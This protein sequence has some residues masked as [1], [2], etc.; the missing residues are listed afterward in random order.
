MNTHTAVNQ[1]NITEENTDEHQNT[2]TATINNKSYSA[3]LNQNTPL[4]FPSKEQAIIFTSIDGA[5][6]QDYLLQLGPVVQPKNIIFS[7]RISNNRICVYLADK[8]TVDNFLKDHGSITVR[9]ETIQARRLITPSE[10]LVLS[11]VSPTIPHDIL[12]TELQK[13]GLKLMSPITF[14]RIGATNPEYSHILSFRRQVYIT[15]PDHIE[16]PDSIEI[17]HDEVFYRIFLSRDSQ[18]CFKCKRSGHIASQCT[19]QSN[20]PPA[21]S[22]KTT[23]NEQSSQEN[24][25]ILTTD[26]IT[27]IDMTDE[28][29]TQPSNKRSVSEILTPTS[30]E[31][32][33]ISNV[34]PENQIFKTPQL[35]LNSKKH[36]LEACTPLNMKLLQDTKTFIDSHTPP[37]ILNTEQ[38]LDLF[39]NTH[40][41][42]DV[43]AIV[44]DY[45][46]DIPALITMLEKVHP[47]ITD[48]NL[49]TRCT[50][51]RKK[52]QKQFECVTYEPESDSSDTTY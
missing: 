50:K 24:S 11:N 23:T 8:S 33:S 19:T 36:K 43:L 26:E 6:L 5:K 15:P 46:T 18:T 39:D 52:L 27:T 12:I 44:K 47:Y 3:A 41:S 2:P 35:T 45:T 9:G 14:L 40:G 10:R 25:S 34:A 20:P 49:K 32:P 4:K 29:Y 51:L 37:L 31:I 7:S 30:E 16:F 22:P 13:L 21:M 38:L 1:L 28:S 17:L 42:K 48:R